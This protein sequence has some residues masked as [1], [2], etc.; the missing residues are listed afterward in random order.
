M[1][2][3]KLPVIFFHGADD[4]FVPCEMSRINYEACQSRKQLVIVPGAAHGLSYPVDP[5]GYLQALRDFF[6]PEG[7]YCEKIPEKS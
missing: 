2:T 6:G 5:E 3:C 1:K 4:D 7:S